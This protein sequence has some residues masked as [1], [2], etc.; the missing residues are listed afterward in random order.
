VGRYALYGGIAAGGMATVHLGRLLGPVGFSRTV[1]I[2]RLHAQYAQDP[3]FVS[4][5][6]DEARLAAR[7]RHPNVVPTLDVVATSGE[8]F[9]V[10]DYVPGESLSRLARAARARMQ[11]MPL[12]IVSAIM[13]GVLHGLHAAHEAKSERG[14]P[15]GIVHRDVSPQNVLVGTDGTARVLDFGVAKA[16]GRTQQTRDGQV[17]GKLSYMAPEQ[18]RGAPVNRKCDVYA[19][20]VV[21][22]ELLTG[23]RLFSA[24]NE[25]ALL[26]RVLEGKVTP[27]SRYLIGSHAP[28]FDAEQARALEVL[29]AVT[30]RAVHADPDVRFATA[31]EMAIALERCVPPATASEVSE[32]VEGVASVVLHERAEVVAEIESAASM[33]L[34]NP[35]P[36]ALMSSLGGATTVSEPPVLSSAPDDLTRVEDSS[37]TSGDPLTQLSSVSVYATPRTAHAE[38]PRR[39]TG[40]KFLGPILGLALLGALVGFVATR[41]REP[42]P[43][44]PPPISA[45]PESPPPASAAAPDPTPAL[46]ATPEPPSA[47]GT[48]AQPTPL[49]KRLPAPGPRPAPP[50]PQP[51]TAQPAAPA[52]GNASDCFWFDSKGMKHINTKDPKCLQ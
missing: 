39:T 23:E 1:A 7:I 21:L 44:A 26:A 49:R 5:F 33:S 30:L 25:G 24:D 45:Q 35:K 14:E 13:S 46:A 38:G 9:L 3:E 16:A 34:A 8:L 32:W 18:L 48:V 17:K 43:A 29:D 12:R 37:Q 28:T 4:M 31:R 36:E 27:P 11:R 15:L 40:A 20:G 50:A 10:M 42:A 41:R 19:A 22:W 6:L 2:K 47:S 52:Q 51:P